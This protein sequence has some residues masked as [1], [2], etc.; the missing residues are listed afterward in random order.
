MVWLR[1]LSFLIP[2]RI[3]ALDRCLPATA[4]RSEDNYGR[5]S[6]V[7]PVSIEFVLRGQELPVYI[8]DI[9]ERD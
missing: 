8:E 3:M 5:S 6:D 2:S 1:L 7:I 4:K 9:C